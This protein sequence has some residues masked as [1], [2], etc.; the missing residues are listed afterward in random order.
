MGTKLKDMA[1]VEMILNEMSLVEKASLVIG[2][3]P[4]SSMAM[5]KYGIPSIWTS[6]CCNGLNIFQYTVEKTYRALEAAKK[7]KGE[8]FDRESFGT[9]GGLLVTVNEMQKKAKEEAAAGI[10]RQKTHDVI[11]YPTGISQAS[12]W[13]PHVAN[14]C[15]KTVAK[16]FVKYGVDLILS[17]NINIHRDP[18]CGRLTE[19][20]SEDPY[21][22]SRIAEAVV[23]GLQDE[24]VIAD[25]KHFAA[26]SQEKD[27][28]KINEKIP[29]RA[30]R[31]I[32]LPGFKACIDA[33]AL[34]VMSAYN[35]INDESCAMNKWLLT[36]VLK[37][38]WKFKG[39]VIS[40]WGASY[41]QVPA[42]AAGTDLTMP[43]P[44]GIQCILDA[45][46]D[47][48]LSEEV[49]NDSCRR[50]MYV[51][52]KSGMLEKKE[53]SFDLEEAKKIVENAARE[54]M[55]LLKNDGT[56]PVQSEQTK[57]CFYGKR[58]KQFAAN[59]EGSGKVPSSFISNPYDRAVEILGSE[60]V[61]Y[62]T[63]S[64]DT[65]LYVAVVGADGQEGADRLT[66]DMDVEDQEALQNA[67]KAA[68]EHNR[69]LVLVC[70]SSGP[71]TLTEYVQ[72]CNAILCPY[73]AGQAGGKVVTDAIFGLYN[74]SGKLTDTWPKAYCDTPSYK[75]YGWENK[76][77][78]YGE[79]IY[80]GY[81]WYDARKIEPLFPF[82]Y[83][84]SYTSF[85]FSDLQVED[86]DVEKEDIMVKV[87]VENTGNMA[88][89]EVVQL[90]V[91]SPK[92]SFDKPEK[93]LKGFQKVYLQPGEKTEVTLTVSK[94]DLAHYH[95]A[96]EEFVTESGT[97]RI[98]VGNS[99]RDIVLSKEIQVIC[100]DP[101]GWNVITG[102]GKLVSNPKA[103][104][105]MN[106]AIGD[107]INLVAAVPIQ[108]APD[109]TLK[110]LWETESS[111]VSTLFSK[112]GK[113]AEEK[114]QAW[115]YIVK[116][117]KKL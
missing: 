56:L 38:E 99:S 90:Y 105:I 5:E 72:D 14:I 68:K 110:E 44:R 10:E 8:K 42:L 50:I 117:F 107:D 6:D 114:K 37:D 96:L 48:S 97:Y 82:G 78:W 104:E 22:V 58:A 91:A 49:L 45:I 77:V 65:T 111:A 55:I 103:V 25:P 84:L 39:C 112:Q 40:D 23:C 60:N 20:Y 75:N 26:N 2:G 52:L 53:V 27:R 109:Y 61:S 46:A 29:M 24:G 113:T 93:E 101:F 11:S 94:E 70:N 12:T 102:I 108:Y 4:M 100:H 92:S 69:K 71:I 76:E 31:E 57:I 79:G 95:T 83:G 13:N 18:L 15:A 33:G 62:Q 74:P 21:L 89:A 43:G 32:Y 87:S 28:L 98:L 66:M 9:M 34:T 106:Q 54:A 41:E 115:D 73:F 7:E 16:E 80:V 36:D 88:G 86:T 30:L 59:S 67:I 116:E 63:P 85:A 47:G 17:P 1:S 51:I 19:S 3:S 35:K 81:R 64:E